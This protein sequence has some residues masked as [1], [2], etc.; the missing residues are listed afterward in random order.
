M[1][2]KGLLA[3]PVCKRLATSSSRPLYFQ[4]RNLN[5]WPSEVVVGEGEK[6]ALKL[7]TGTLAK[8]ADGAAVAQVGGTAVMATVCRGKTIAGQSFLPMTVDYRQKAAAAGRIPTNMLRRELGASER[9]IL[10]SRLVDRSLRP[11]AP[12][13]FH[14]EI[15]IACNLLSLDQRGSCDPE[16]LSVNA[17]SLA[18][19]LS[20][21]PWMG[22]VG[23]VRVGLVG[24]EVVLNPSRRELKA[25]KVNLVVVATS[26]GKCTMLEGDA[27]RVPTSDFL[28]CVNRGLEEGAEVARKIEELGGREG[29]VKRTGDISPAPSAELRA[30]VKRLAWQKLQAIFTDYQLDK[31]SRDK[32]MREVY[33]EVTRQCKLSHPAVEGEMM[34]TALQEVTK[35]VIRHLAFHDAKRVDGRA[36]DQL[37]PISCQVGLHEPLHGSSLFQRGQT[38][39]LCTVALDSLAAAQRLD[40]MSALT[41]GLREKNFML[42][43]EFPSYATGEVGRGGGSMGR[44]ELGHGALA[45]RAL[46]QVLPEETEFTTRLTSEVLESNGSSSMA[47]ICGG[48]LALMDA[49]VKLKEAASGV[50]MGLLEREGHGHRVLTDIMGMEDFFGDMDFKFA[51]SR[52]GVCAIQADVKVPGISSAVIEEAVRGGMEANH[53]IMDIME[54]TLSRPVLSKSCWPVSKTIEVAAHQRAKLLGPGGITLRR[55]QEDTGVSIN[56]QDEGSW[57]IFAP[58]QAAMEEAEERL[59]QV[60]LDERAPELEFGSIYTG[61]IVSILDRG[62][63]IQLHPAID[64]VLLPN[65]QLGNQRISHPSALNLTVGQDLQVK[66]YGRDPASGKMRLS[67]KVITVAKETAVRDLHRATQRSKTSPSNSPSPPPESP[68]TEP[69]I[70]ER[71]AA[72]RAKR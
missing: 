19:A 42:H 26:S 62:V 34:N 29:K 4:M 8:L 13:G 35:A 56:Q 57:T 10:T 50:A 40:A 68:P 37:R 7:S 17:A 72:L 14:D 65:N 63:M 2:F 24:E 71:I 58:S 61:K 33:A 28:K 6:S 11:L 48:S 32:A 51:A 44:R 66:Y 45:E 67:R 9:E 3:A 36:L 53:R 23:A 31:L 1:G 52:S 18:L 41:G 46:R 25:S 69:T 47:S 54:N 15:S 55:I 27:G 43:Y 22:A 30:D 60:M 49:G 64:P 59:D 5:R 16:V 20:T 38:Q 12:P 70:Q 39:V 21:L